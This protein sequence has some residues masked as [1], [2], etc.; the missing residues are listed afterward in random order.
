MQF[1]CLSNPKNCFKLSP[2]AFGVLSELDLEKRGFN[3]SAWAF[4]LLVLYVSILY[5]IAAFWSLVQTSER[6]EQKH[7]NCFEK[8]FTITAFCSLTAF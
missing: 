2:N 8:V 7:S 5:S 1:H 3:P 4:K 6:I